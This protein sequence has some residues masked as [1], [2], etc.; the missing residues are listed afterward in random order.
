VTHDYVEALA[1]GDRIGVLDHGELIQVGPPEEVYSRPVN[2][3]VARHLGQPEI[4]LID[5]NVT[6]MNGSVHLKG[7]KNPKLQFILDG[8]RAKVLKQS[9]CQNVRIG[10]RPHKIIRGPVGDGDLVGEVYVYE[11]AVIFGQLLVD[12]G[13]Y[14]LTVLT[15]ASDRFDIGQKVGLEISSKDVY[16]FDPRTGKNLEAAH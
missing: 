16:L 14:M 8:N 12:F 13:G 6:S 5:M 10:I 1:L 2:E 9:N 7:V 4:N 15:K 11:P 3:F